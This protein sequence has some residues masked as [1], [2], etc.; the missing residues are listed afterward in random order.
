MEPPPKRIRIPGDTVVFNVGG[1]HF[2]I[3]ALVIQRRPST[4]LA[5]LLDDI[6]TDSSQHIFVDANPDR[7]QYI[8]DWYRYG[9]AQH[10]LQTCAASRRALLHAS[11]RGE[12]E[13]MCLFSG[14][15]TRTGG[16]RS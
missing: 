11:R 7:F 9:S 5:N 6:G 10:L 8:V 13:R 4:L 16:W 3:L 14:L 1:R 15:S 2:E 12:N